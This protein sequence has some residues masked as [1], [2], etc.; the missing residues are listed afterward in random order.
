VK[1]PHLFGIALFC[2]SVLHR[3]AAP[4]LG[5]IVDLFNSYNGFKGTG[6]YFH[7]LQAGYN[8]MLPS[9]LVVGFEADINTPSVIAGDQLISSPLIGQADYNDT[10]LLSGTARGRI[11]MP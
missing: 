7:G 10:V 5:G 1:F 3:S 6:S 4:A 2:V 9:R 11:V 8:A